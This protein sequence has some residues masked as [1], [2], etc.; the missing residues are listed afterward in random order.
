MDQEFK[1][2]LGYT[3]CLM[4][5]SHAGRALVWRMLAHGSVCALPALAPFFGSWGV[6]E[7]K[8]AGHS[9][10]QEEDQGSMSDSVGSLMLGTQIGHW[11]SRD[12]RRE[13]EEG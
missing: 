13:E 2:I 8:L 11:H 7:I 10:K 6:R 4:K 1:S 5:A 9:E 12:V 3:A